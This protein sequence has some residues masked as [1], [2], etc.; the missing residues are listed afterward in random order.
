MT[1]D[2]AE[3]VHTDAAPAELIAHVQAIGNAVNVN[4]NPPDQTPRFAY[5]LSVFPLDGAPFVMTSNA[6]REP[7][8]QMLEHAAAQMRMIISLDQAQ[9]AAEPRIVQGSIGAL[10]F[11]DA[12]LGEMVHDVSRALQ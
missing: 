5:L 4:L 1:S 8:L 10:D 3:D 7:Q 2:Q 6:D 12:D 11:S 9:A